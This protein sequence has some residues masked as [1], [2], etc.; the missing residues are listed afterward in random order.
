MKIESIKLRGFIGIKKGLGL[1]DLAL[2][3]SSLSGLVAIAGQ[4]GR[5]KTSLLENLQPF[6]AFASRKRALQHHVFLRDSYREL[7]FRWNG[8]VYRT[9]LKIDCDSERQEG[10]IWKNGDPQVNGKVRDYDRYI[11]GLFGSSRLFFNSVFCAQGAEKITDMTPGQL[12]SLFTEFLRLDRYVEWE[13]TAKQIGQVLSGKA[14]QLQKEVQH[15]ERIVGEIEGLRIKLIT[16]RQR[17]EQQNKRTQGLA[18][19][20][21]RVKNELDIASETESKNRVLRAKLDAYSESH[22]AAR[23][24]LAAIEGDAREEIERFGR[25]IA[26]LEGEIARYKGI[27]EEGDRITSAVRESE[28]AAA[29]LAGLLKDLEDTRAKNDEA[30][31]SIGRVKEELAKAKAEKA[32]LSEAKDLAVLEARLKAAKEDLKTLNL[33]DPACRSTTCSFIARSI[34]SQKAIPGLERQ[35]GE[36]KAEQEKRLEAVEKDIR[37]ATERLRS[38]EGEQGKLGESIARVKKAITEQQQI[39]SRNK[40]FG[41]KASQLETAR[42]AVS[43]TDDRL[44]ALVKDRHLAKEKWDKKVRAKQEEIRVLAKMKEEV[45]AGIDEK[46]ESRVAELKGKIE[47]LQGEFAQGEKACAE[48]SR[49]IAVLENQLQQAEREKEKLAALQGEIGRVKNEVSEWAYLQTACGANGLRAL[50]IDSVAPAISAYANELLSQ[51]FGPL[52]TVRLRTQDEEGREVLQVLVMR[53]D[54]SEPLLENLSGGEKI[55]ILKALRLAMTLISKEKSGHNF[56]TCLADEEDGALDVENALN[57]IRLYRAFMVSG[58]FESCFF[59]SHKPE[60]VAMA[61][62]QVLF[63]SGGVEVNAGA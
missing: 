7:S 57:F 42:A 24:D 21:E 6:R 16:E 49:N 28:E 56:L 44:F 59:I 61:D 25:E 17:Y 13:Q 37:S 38:L 36:L 41:D 27:L 55:W 29:R 43:S 15:L 50:E 53:E 11:E 32:S 40:A 2:D 23:R 60:C 63:Q 34:E 35:I 10:F 19:E 52:F 30:Q 39:I 48:T 8:D 22:E 45:K 4:N 26:K 18:G 12:K 31:G 58:G 5:G 3:L 1:D 62:H 47:A 20:L 46:A 51:A 33:R 9:L 14:N 54:G